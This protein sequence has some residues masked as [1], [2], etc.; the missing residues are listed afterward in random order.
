[1]FF[2]RAFPSGNRPGLPRQQEIRFPPPRNVNRARPAN[3]DDVT[4]DNSPFKKF[5]FEILDRARLTE[6]HKSE[7]WKAGHIQLLQSFTHESYGDGQ[8][9]NYFEFLGDTVVGLFV[10]FY[11][12]ERFPNIRNAKWVTRIKHNLISKRYLGQYAMDAG[13]FPYIRFGDRMLAAIEENPDFKT[14]ITYLGLLEDVLESFFGALAIVITG[15]GYSYG[16]A[17]QTCFEIL[18]TFLDTR[19]ISLDYR[20]LFDPITRLKEFYDSRKDGKGWAWDMKGVYVEKGTYDPE[21]RVE[22]PPFHATV[23]GW[24]LGDRSQIF[25]NRVELGRATGPNKQ[26]AKLAASEMALRTLAEKYQIYEP[27]GRPDDVKVRK[28]KY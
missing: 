6:K 11:I 10:A 24:P 20:D 21:T 28:N 14:N 3:S 26:D 16:S 15:L 23:Y 27:I 2:A 25:Q 7:I 22:G 19:E 17:T 12:N 1:M 8:D 13:F 5:V 4:T 18:R 9:Y